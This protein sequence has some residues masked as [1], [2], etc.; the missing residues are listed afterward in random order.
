MVAEQVADK[1]RARDLIV[2]LV[3][4]ETLRRPG[5]FTAG[6]AGYRQRELPIKNE[7]VDLGKYD[8]VVFG[9]PVWAG[10]PAPVLKS[11]LEK[12]PQGVQTP[13]ACFLVGGNKVNAQERAIVALA[14]WIKK[15]GLPMREPVLVVQAGRGQV[16]A[17]NLSVDEFVSQIM[18]VAVSHRS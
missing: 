5:F 13:V 8:F 2:D 15:K 10:Y 18:P 4:I 7:G 6:S 1:L 14:S 11:F 16:R 17:E 3:E 9:V 12:V